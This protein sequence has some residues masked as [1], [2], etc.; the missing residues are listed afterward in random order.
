[1][2]IRRIFA[3]LL[4][5]VY[6]TRRTVEVGI[7]LPF[8]SVMSVIVFGFVNS[9]LSV[10]SGKTVANYLF[11]GTILWEV[12]RITQYSMSVGALWNVWSRNLA[13]MFI[14]PL[15]LREYM[16]AQMFSSGLKS[17]VIVSA[18]SL[19]AATLFDFNITAL[20]PL[21]LVLFFLNLMFFAWSIG[22]S[23]LGVIFRFGTRVQALAWGTVF[24]F[25]PLTASFFP[26]DV[27]PP[28]LQVIARLIPAT[29]VF[30]A[31]RRALTE[32]SVA[33][34]LMG[35]ALLQ[36]AIYFALAAW[37]FNYMFRRSRETGP[38]AR[39]EE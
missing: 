14:T 16:V 9:Y 6:I 19:L 31:A 25:Q 32:Q 10:T 7:D 3:I 33:W 28:F 23:V 37:F 13:N 2:S 8:F 29:Y 15:S 5:E 17:L 20:G 1:M 12:V 30:E 11:M 22:L 35:M 21:N 24:L 18:L 39:N 4:Q 34:E 26:V 36:N 27:L 38:F